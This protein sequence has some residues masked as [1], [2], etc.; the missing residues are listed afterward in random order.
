MTK[1]SLKEKVYTIIRN[2]I[3]TRAV[4]GGTR[5]IETEVAA[6][7][8]VSRT[9]VREALQRLSHE[10]FVRAIPRAGYLVEELPDDDIQ[11]L[12]STR[13][14]I[15]QA[16]ARKAAAYISA[17]ELKEMDDNLEQARAAAKAGD[18]AELAGLDTA[19][20]TILYK[21]ARSRHLFRICKNM[22]DLSSRYQR[23]LHQQETLAGECLAQHL[24]VFQALL[25][26]NGDGAA[27]ALAAHGESA[28]RHLKEILKKQRSDTFGRD[29][30]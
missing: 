27:K 26:K 10:K 7:L 13:M 8:S 1:P 17:T 15:E 19:F 21:A 6:R 23:D 24:Q 14:D 9:P 20:H 5:L 3:L 12:F 30:I 25:A 29:M 11:D 22:S 16:A 28:C 2:D 18:A 4:P